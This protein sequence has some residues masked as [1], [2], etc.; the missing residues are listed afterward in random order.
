MKKI[1]N[2]KWVYPVTMKWTDEHVMD[3]EKNHV[4]L[5]NKNQSYEKEKL[6]QERARDFMI[7]NKTANLKETVNG[8]RGN[9]SQ[10]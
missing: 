3:R 2:K 4:P 8:D 9:M 7:I 5:A 10:P 6:N 1:L